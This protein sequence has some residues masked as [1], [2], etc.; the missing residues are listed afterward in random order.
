MDS[1]EF[2]THGKA[3]VDFIADYLDSL[4]DRPVL[5]SVEPGYL[6]HM[7]PAKAPENPETWEDIMKDVERVVMPGV[8]TCTTYLQ[9]LRKP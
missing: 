4:R 7:I 3:M 5:P 8:S 6:R 1:S 9:A 2:R